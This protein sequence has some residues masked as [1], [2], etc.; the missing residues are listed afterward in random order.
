LAFQIVDDVLGIW[1]Q[2]EVTGKSSQDDLLSRKKTLPVIHGLE[3]SPQFSQLWSSEQNDPDDIEKMRNTL[4]D[5]RADEYARKIAQKATARAL[6][7]LGNALPKEPA[8]TELSSLTSQ[9][10]TRNR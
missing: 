10:V 3:I 5:A 6:R 9:M 4:E 1:G 8:A 2:T 7:A